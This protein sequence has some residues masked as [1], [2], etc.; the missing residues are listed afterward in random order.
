[1]TD[2]QRPPIYGLGGTEL[3]RIFNYLD[4]GLDQ[5]HFSGVMQHTKG[6]RNMPKEMRPRYLYQR[7]ARLPRK[8]RPKNLKKALA[9][10]T[11]WIK[12]KNRC[13]VCLEQHFTYLDQIIGYG[14][15][16]CFRCI[17]AFHE[18]YRCGCG[19]SF[20]LKE[21]IS[22]TGEFLTLSCEKHALWERW[23]AEAP[24]QP[25]PYT[26][27]EWFE[28]E[29]GHPVEDFD[30]ERCYEQ[31]QLS[32]PRC[33]PGTIRSKDLQWS[34]EKKKRGGKELCIVQ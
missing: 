34:R 26:W 31:I 21:S 14:H 33:K 2:Q 10:T 18:P 11:K 23:A 16:L 25:L 28:R 17:K 15:T 5:F 30:A 24:G 27:S 3:S 1:M 32:E 7:M 29:W 13:N 19:G 22:P 4:V 9:E 12:D 6:G 20:R 8:Q